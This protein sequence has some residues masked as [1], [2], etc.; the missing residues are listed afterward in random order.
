MDWI[1][2][3]N[4]FMSYDFHQSNFANLVTLL[5]NNN[6]SLGRTTFQRVV[7][8]ILRLQRWSEDE[9]V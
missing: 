2:R 6:T 4:L 7:G 8:L 3:L 9:Q 5:Y 1:I